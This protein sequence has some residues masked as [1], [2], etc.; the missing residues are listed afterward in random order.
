ML[1]SMTRFISWCRGRPSVALE[2]SAGGFCRMVRSAYVSSFCERKWSKC[3]GNIR[4]SSCVKLNRSKP[5]KH[6]MTQLFAVEHDTTRERS[7]TI[8]QSRWTTY[9]RCNSVINVSYTTRGH[10]IMDRNETLSLLID[11]M[12]EAIIIVLRE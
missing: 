2:K 6:D 7:Q 5:S 11:V 4:Y 1:G 12:L 10:F 3:D 8:N 9:T